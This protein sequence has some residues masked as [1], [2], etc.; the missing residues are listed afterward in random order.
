M[1]TDVEMPEMDGLEL[2]EAIR[3]AQRAVV[4]ARD[5][6]DVARATKRIAGAG[7]EAGADAYI[8]KRGF[9]QHALLETVERLVGPVIAGRGTRVLVCEDSTT[10]AVALTRTLEHDG[11]IEVVGVC[12]TAEA[13]IV[14]S[15]RACS[16]TSSRW[17][18]SCRGCPA[19]RRSSRS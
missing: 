13:A 4:A 8:V 2:T 9:D 10:Y 16:P 6:R 11:D 12:P 3:A 1:I 17:T 19:S 14:G 15:A 7:V 18:S 5:R